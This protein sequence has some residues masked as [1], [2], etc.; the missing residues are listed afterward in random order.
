M[1]TFLLW[2]LSLSS[3]AFAADSYDH[4]ALNFFD[5]YQYKT[6]YT[7]IEQPF[8]AIQE[9]A[10]GQENQMHLINTGIGA[11]YKRLDM[12][13]RAKKHIELEYFIFSSKKKSPKATENGEERSTKLIL[14]KLIDK[15]VAGVMVRL[16]IDKSAT[17]FQFDENHVTAVKR[18]ILKRGGKNPNF[19]EVRYYNSHLYHLPTQ[20]IPDFLN[21]SNFRNHRKLISIDDS[22]AITG[23]RN[24]EDKYFDLDHSYNFIDRDIWVQGSVV[25][26]MRASFDKFWDSKIVN[27]P[28]VK[29]QLSKAPSQEELQVSHFLKMSDADLALQQKV[30]A[31][32]ESAYNMADTH[33]CPRTVFAT[34]KPIENVFVRF[35]NEKN[36]GILCKSEN[37]YKE[38]YRIT[39]RVIGAFARSLNTNDELYIDSPYV[40]LNTR[41]GAVLKLLTEKKVKINVFTNSLSSTDA[42]YAAAAF[43]R[44]ADKFAQSGVK[45]MIHGSDW[46]PTPFVA[47]PEV[48]KAR[49]G[50]HVK[51]HLYGD[52]A[53]FVGTY[54]IDN[55]SS[56]YNTEMGIFCE[57]SSALNAELRKEMQGLVQDIGYH[58]I[59]ENT[60][61]SMKKGT[62]ENP[63]GRGGDEKK[64]QM[65][66]MMIP[67]ELFQFL[68]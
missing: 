57:G 27:Q 11:L 33:S 46:R 59:N 55:R 14:N 8:V 50:T 9:A 4:W 41:S 44:E 24:I 18:E 34:D 28:N 17:V 21:V 31:L 60:A 52:K 43:Y 7:K 35:C 39:E 62:Q 63:L 45:L 42:T 15:A 22:E 54:N 37:N 66:L 61:V 49:W 10:K 2:V 36:E 16:L 58:L 67:V 53:L 20:Y 40:M 48:E 5:V 38:K 26:F 51:S 3:F 23:G 1:K 25:P 6:P 65:N 30:M 12:I 32:G 19:F 13:D 47:E 56:F 64:T 29:K 68:M